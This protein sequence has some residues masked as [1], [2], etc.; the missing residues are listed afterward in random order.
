MG[1][2]RDYWVR[3][4]PIETEI[5]QIQNSKEVS[6]HFELYE[7]VAGASYCNHQQFQDFAQGQY[8]KMFE[9]NSGGQTGEP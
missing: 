9:I 4:Y 6:T 7:E 2:N 1:Y 8:R 5:E 3:I